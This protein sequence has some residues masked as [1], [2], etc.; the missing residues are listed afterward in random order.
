MF[1]TALAVCLVASACGDPG[2]E[3]AVEGC[4]EWAGVGAATPYLG[5]RSPDAQQPLPVTRNVQFSS[6]LFY[7]AGLCERPL[8][9]I[10]GR[11]R[12]LTGFVCWTH[13]YIPAFLAYD[14]SDTWNTC[15]DVEVVL[16][17]LDIIRETGN[18]FYAE[19]GA[20]F[21]GCSRSWS[22]VLFQVNATH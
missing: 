16:Y 7:L 17:S 18:E 6:S 4:D 11:F 13:A 15:A 19:G 21:F 9:L 12:D 20:A 14:S 8:P 5:A 10:D 22:A 2:G 1:R 3:C